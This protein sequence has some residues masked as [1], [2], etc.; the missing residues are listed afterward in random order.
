MTEIGSEFSNVPT[1]EHENHL[2][3]RNTVWYLSGR[4]ALRAII[5]DIKKKNSFK[6]VGIPS[7]CCDSMIAPFIAQGIEVKFYSVVCVEKGLQI[8]LSPVEKTDAI[9]ILDYF[10]FKRPLN[11]NFN[12]IVI[13]DATHSVFLENT[14]NADYTFGSLRKWAGFYTGGFAF[15]KDGNLETKETESDFTYIETRKLAMQEKNKYL[16]GEIN[17]K[18]FLQLFSTAEK[19][20]DLLSNG[21][22]DPRDVMLAKKLDIS[23]IK[24]K[25]REN[26]AFLIKELG[27]LSLFKEMKDDDCPLFVPVIVP[28]G[29]RTTLRKYLIGKQIYCPVH[30]PETELHNLSD[31]E[32]FIYENEISIVC[33]QRYSLSDM[34]RIVQ[35]VKSFLIE[36]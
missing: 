31:E 33:D 15:S 18:E 23:F 28:S 34:N 6:T 27:D 10:G 22:A 25:R 36:R 20:L 24:E 12:G 17:S 3:P 30:W 11:F 9:L 21:K 2:F 13:F 8:D 1:L 19:V 5:N 4:C 26:A 29:K 35:E 32:K 7:W 16:R 14:Y